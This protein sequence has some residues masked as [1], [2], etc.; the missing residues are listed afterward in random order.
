MPRGGFSRRGQR[1][2]A[3]QVRHPRRPHTPRTRPHRTPEAQGGRGSMS[4]PYYQDE[5]VTVHAG[6]CLEV[7]RTLPDASVH[8][9]VTDPPYGLANTSPE[10]VADTIVRWVNG[11]RDY[12]PG[13][14]G[15]MGNA[16]DAFVPPVAVWD[17]CMRVLKPGGHLLAFAGSRTHDLMSLALRLAGFEIRDSIA[18]L[19]G[20]GFPQSLAVPKALD[21]A[22]GAER[23]TKGW[24]TRDRVGVFAGDGGDTTATSGNLQCPDCLKWKFAPDYC[25]CPRDNGAQTDEAKQW[26]GWGTA[27]KPAFEP[28]VVARKPLTAPG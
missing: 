21:K 17:E 14:A 8:A 2:Q 11:D 5:Q 16:W 28:I 25:K 7:L 6:D 1:Q 9:V 4:A 18:W 22:A 15:F 19:Y 27:L 24:L 10:Q 20:S 3:R 26:D 12:S 13:G 23:E